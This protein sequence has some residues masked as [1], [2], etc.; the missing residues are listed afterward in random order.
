MSESEPAEK[1]KKTNPT[2]KQ[3]NKKTKENQ[4]KTVRNCEEGSIY[5]TLKDSQIYHMCLLFGLL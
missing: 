4:W 5:K 1:K 3:T 2:N